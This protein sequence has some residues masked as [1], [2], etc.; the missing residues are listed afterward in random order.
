MQSFKDT[1]DKD[2]SIQLPAIRTEKKTGDVVVRT[3]SIRGLLQQ[4]GV[5]AIAR[6]RPQP[7]L[8][9]R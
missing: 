4:V 7:R 5:P 8:F 6:S 9:Q 1:E 2:P 3:F